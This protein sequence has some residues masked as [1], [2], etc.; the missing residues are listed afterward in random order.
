MLDWRNPNPDSPNS[1]NKNQTPV[2]TNL[3]CAFW[4]CRATA[5]AIHITTWRVQERLRP[6]Q[7]RLVR[8][9]GPVVVACA[10][11]DGLFALNAIALTNNSFHFQSKERMNN[12]IEFTEKRW[13][14]SEVIALRLIP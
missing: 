10:Q 9:Q 14:E 7:Y 2:K 1:S 5:T 12:K 11:L 8:M 6:R 3:P 4:R 13:A